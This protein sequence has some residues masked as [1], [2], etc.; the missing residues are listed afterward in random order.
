MRRDAD[1]FYLELA[2][3]GEGGGSFHDIFNLD[4]SE[5]LIEDFAC[6]ISRSILLQGR[7]YITQDHV[8]FHSS[9]FGHRTIALL[10]FESIGSLRKVTHALINPGIEIVDTDGEVYSF[11]SFFFRDHTFKILKELWRI[12]HRK[13]PLLF[14]PAAV[15]G[16]S[17]GRSALASPSSAAD[18]AG[19]ARSAAHRP[20][21]VVDGFA[22][23]RGAS[24][25]QPP[26]PRSLGTSLSA[27][28][29]HSPLS[30]GGR[31]AHGCAPPASSPAQSQPQP[32]ADGGGSAER[33]PHVPPRPPERRVPPA[34]AAADSPL[35]L[36]RM[37]SRSSD[38]SASA[39]D[40]GGREVDELVRARARAAAAAA[41]VRQAA[42]PPRR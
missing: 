19:A 31:F 20:G 25:P 39:L 3:G 27:P 12:H 10:H 29:Q 37:L 4:Y 42:P 8:C 26:T 24:P 5:A 6:A 21:R 17:A 38:G 30:A 13:R 14:P 11:A 16:G 36:R 18:A 9:L 34:P 28:G 33:A 40:D 32:A 1:A 22:A 41:C 23:G 35:R 2:D 7:M 15:G